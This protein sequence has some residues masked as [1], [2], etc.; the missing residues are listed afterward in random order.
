[1]NFGASG[2]I[3]GRARIL[4]SFQIPKNT[5]LIFFWPRGPPG[6]ESPKFIHQNFG[7]KRP[8]PPENRATAP[9]LRSSSNSVGFSKTAEN[10]PL[11]STST[12]WH[13]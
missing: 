10:D 12:F 4:L 9:I 8:R 2:P 11:K 7:P 6:P 13:F 1:L 5:T 3:R